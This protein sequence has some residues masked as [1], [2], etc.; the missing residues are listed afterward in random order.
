M[1][2][3]GYIAINWVLALFWLVV[4]VAVCMSCFILFARSL[5]S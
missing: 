4:I 5:N 2:R 3:V 1:D